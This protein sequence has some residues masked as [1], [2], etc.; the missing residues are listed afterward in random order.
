MGTFELTMV[1]DIE[2]LD[3]C[4]DSE[5]GVVAAEVVLV[6]VVVR[7]APVVDTFLTWSPQ[8]SQTARARLQWFILSIGICAVRSGCIVL[9]VDWDPLFTQNGPWSSLSLTLQRCYTF[10]PTRSGHMFWIVLEHE[11][12]IQRRE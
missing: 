3:V 5:V 10:G 11:L 12:A 4:G 8:A 9:T 1:V 6:F 2:L 7:G